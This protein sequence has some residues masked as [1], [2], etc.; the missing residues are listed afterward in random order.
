[1]GD[2]VKTFSVYRYR[3]INLC[4][5]TKSVERFDDVVEKEVDPITETELEQ[6]LQYE[7][8]RETVDDSDVSALY[9]EFRNAKLSE[10][11]KNNPNERQRIRRNDSDI[12]VFED[13]KDLMVVPLRG[14]NYTTG[15]L[16]RSALNIKE[17]SRLI[18]EEFDFSEDF[19]YWMFNHYLNNS[20]QIV[21]LDEE[22][23]ELKII[24]L[25]G[26]SGETRDTINK[27]TSDGS[28][29]SKILWTL[30]FLFTNEKIMSITPE[31]EHIVIRE[32]ASFTE[33]IKLDLTLTGTYKVGVNDHIGSRFMD[34]NSKGTIAYLILY[35][36]KI[37][38][39]KLKLAYQNDIKKGSWSPHVKKQFI[40]SIGSEIEDQ[41]SHILEEIDSELEEA[42]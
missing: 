5:I 33:T 14:K 27:I 10:K 21:N 23:R 1:M 25:T 28:R 42:E 37:L 26:F 7:K 12:I 6:E 39:P 13:G 34:K 4:E 20:G 2:I 32:S 3:D 35:T 40:R 19:F 36:Y 9:L 30:A 18:N 38:V 8:L 17:D 15:S 31:L 22:D 24:S 16:I 11:H 29:I 41:V